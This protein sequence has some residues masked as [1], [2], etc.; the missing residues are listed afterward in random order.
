MSLRKK[1][2]VQESENTICIHSESRK[3]SAKALYTFFRFFSTSATI[4]SPGVSLFVPIHT[5]RT[6]TRRSRN[7]FRKVD[8]Y[9]FGEMMDGNLLILLSDDLHRRHVSLQPYE[10]Q[11][12]S[13]FFIHIRSHDIIFFGCQRSKAISFNK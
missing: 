6:R 4:G 5:L 3:M 8:D 13:K 11:K 7:F 9:G 12:T 1:N 10:P 2:K